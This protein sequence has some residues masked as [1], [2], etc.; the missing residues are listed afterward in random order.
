MVLVS[1]NT[2]F[3]GDL[4][5][6]IDVPLFPRY[7]SSGS[8]RGRTLL[9]KHRRQLRSVLVA[10]GTRVRPAMFTHCVTEP[11]RL[12]FTVDQTWGCLPFHGY[13]SGC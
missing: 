3:G 4:R 12:W 9:E 13:V 11:S 10:F 2:E 8:C 7:P 1:S 6:A 5:P